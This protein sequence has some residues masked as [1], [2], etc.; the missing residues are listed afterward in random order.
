MKA[1][2][3]NHDKVVQLLITAGAKLDLLHQVWWMIMWIQ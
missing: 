1:S 2:I 3:E